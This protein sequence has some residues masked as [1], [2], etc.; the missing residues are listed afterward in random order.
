MVYEQKYGAQKNETEESK[1][2]KD[3]KASAAKIEDKYKPEPNEQK[4]RAHVRINLN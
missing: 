2:G 3:A 1:G 4:I